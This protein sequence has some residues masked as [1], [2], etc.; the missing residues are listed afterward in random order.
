MTAQTYQATELTWIL[1]V[2]WLASTILGAVIV[3]YWSSIRGRQ[4]KRNS[5]RFSLLW[6]R[7]PLV[8]LVNGLW[9]TAMFF[10]LSPTPAIGTLLCLWIP[11]LY[12][13]GLAYSRFRR[14]VRILAEMEQT[15]EER[16]QRDTSEM[17]A[18]DRDESD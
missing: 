9:L 12:A 3:F 4:L 11:L 16:R 13:G 2:A 18:K 8:L 10:S 6:S 5:E 1:L 14:G 17:Q 15:Q 7:L